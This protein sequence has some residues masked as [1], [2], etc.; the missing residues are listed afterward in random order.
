VAKAGIDILVTVGPLAKH[1]A[2]GARAAGMHE[3]AMWPLSTPD[4]ASEMLT[5]LLEP[6]DVVLVKASRSVGLERVV[7]GIVQPGA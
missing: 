5:T 1:I 4:G 7:E 3:G 6:G 2:D